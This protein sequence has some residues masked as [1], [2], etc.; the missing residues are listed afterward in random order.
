M[1]IAPVLA[2]LFFPKGTRE[3]HNPV[4]TWLT[5]GVPQGCCGSAIQL[6]WVTVARGVA[7]LG[8]G[9]VSCAGRRDRLGVPAASG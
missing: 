6:R 7:G 3:W 9:A 8:R 4:M 5:H 2:S 1:L